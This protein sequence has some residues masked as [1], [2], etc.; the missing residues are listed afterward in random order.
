MDHWDGRPGLLGM[1]LDLGETA[2]VSGGDDVGAGRLQIGDFALP[3]FLRGIRFFDIVAPRGS[4]TELPFGGLGDF[5]AGN[6]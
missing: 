3:E 5:D 2:N 4:A 6:C 1:K